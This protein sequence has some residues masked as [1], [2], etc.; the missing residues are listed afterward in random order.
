VVVGESPIL[1]VGEFGFERLAQ[2]L[3]T[4]LGGHTASAQVFPLAFT[5]SPEN[6]VRLN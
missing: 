4:D 1:A 5:A 2:C 3:H 6:H